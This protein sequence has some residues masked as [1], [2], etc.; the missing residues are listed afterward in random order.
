[1]LNIIKFRLCLNELRPILSE[2]AVLR[3]N[4][5]IHP[6]LTA[7]K[8]GLSRQKITF[9]RRYL[10]PDFGPGNPNS[11]RCS[12]RIPLDKLRRSPQGTCP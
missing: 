10:A 1:M 5:F 6:E 9:I 12:K 3:Q 8:M 2:F 7:E 11:W 4:T